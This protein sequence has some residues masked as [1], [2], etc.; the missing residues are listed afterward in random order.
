MRFHDKVKV[1]HIEAKGKRLPVSAM[2]VWG[3][4]FNRNAG[5]EEGDIDG[6]EDDYVMNEAI[7]S[8]EENLNDFEDGMEIVDRLKSDLFAEGADDQDGLK[9]SIFSLFFLNFV[10]RKYFRAQKTCRCVASTNIGTGSRKRSKKGLGTTRRSQC[11]REASKLA[12]R[13]GPGVRTSHEGSSCG[14]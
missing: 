9:Q 1:K 6:G 10:S 14:H 4:R 7:E 5:V 11:S 13:R 2:S 3:G 8:S 12:L